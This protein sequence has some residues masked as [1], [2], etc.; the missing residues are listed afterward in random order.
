M[1]THFTDEKNQSEIQALG[2][3]CQQVSQEPPSWASQL[4]SG[5]GGVMQAVVSK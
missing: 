3:H 1:A 4:W 5:D 2:Q